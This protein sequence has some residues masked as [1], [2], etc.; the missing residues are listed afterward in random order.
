VTY[1]NYDGPA[2]AWLQPETEMAVK[3]YPH[4]HVEVH[5][6]ADGNDTVAI[7]VSEKCSVELWDAH[8]TANL[9]CSVAELSQFRII[10][11][12]EAETLLSPSTIGALEQN[13]V[14]QGGR[15]TTWAMFIVTPDS[16]QPDG[17]PYTG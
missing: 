11:R 17:K 2:L 3:S 7:E 14:A 5:R 4:A 16:I 12:A 15:V 1:F 6:Y 10:S 9:G 8:P 13:A